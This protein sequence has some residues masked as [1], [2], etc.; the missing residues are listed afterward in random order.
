MA[1]TQI[2][3][4]LLPEEPLAAI[5][6]KPVRYTVLGQMMRFGAVGVVNTGID[7]GTLNLLLWRFPT[8]NA[9]TLLIYNS[10]A[11]L[12]GAL[13]SFILNKYWTFQARRA[14]SGSEILRF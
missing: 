9:N 12:L 10:I 11:F 14:A 3:G 8:H 7:I 5:T 4:R 2:T 6:P 1:D 13:N